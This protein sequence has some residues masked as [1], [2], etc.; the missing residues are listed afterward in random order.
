M[1]RIGVLRQQQSRIEPLAVVKRKLW[2][3]LN[4]ESLVFMRSDNLPEAPEVSFFT[5][6]GVFLIT[7]ATLMYEI[8]LTRI[9]SVTMW[10]HFAF[11]AI[12]LAMFGMTVGAL[13]V[14]QYPELFQGPRTRRA[15]AASALG[16]ASTAVTTTFLH[17]TVPF[18]SQRILAFAWIL[19]G[20]ILFAVPFYFSGVCVCLALTK[21]PQRAG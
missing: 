20:Y 13:R 12:S 16:F 17:L 7:L 11:A 15:M 6:A 4:R 14:Y 21:F 10:Y 5:I 18:A 9:F 3:F 19:L 8:L 2:N 1:H